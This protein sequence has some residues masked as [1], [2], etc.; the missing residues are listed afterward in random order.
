M[1]KFISITLLML[2]AINTYGQ[3]K[4]ISARQVSVV[5]RNFIHDNYPAAKNLKFYSEQGDGKIYTEAE[6][7][8]E[9]AKHALKFLGDSLVETE[10]SI[11]FSNI[12]ISKRQKIQH[13]LDSMFV[14]YKVLE[15]QEVNPATWPLYEINIK[16]ASGSYFE[17]YFDK[18][19]KFIRKTELLIKPI[20]SLF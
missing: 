19:G 7:K 1:N 6:F 14:K 10:V 17:L 5:V 12:P 11:D 3:E 15:C 18:T 16:T 4:R 20:P 8:Q 13:T 9:K 2:M